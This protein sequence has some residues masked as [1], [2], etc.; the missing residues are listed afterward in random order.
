[1]INQKPCIKFKLLN[2]QPEIFDSKVGGFGY[3]PHDR[4]FPMAKEGNQL[5][6]LAQIDCSQVDFEPFPKS[7]LLQFWIL[8][9][10][11]YG[12]FD[13][14]EQD[15]FRVIYYPEIDR[16]VTKE[17]IQKKIIKSEYDED[18]YNMP[19]FGEFGM[20]FSEGK[21][22][23][24]D[25]F[26]EFVE[27]DEEREYAMATGTYAEKYSGEEETQYVTD[28]VH[29]QIGGYPYFTQDDPRYSQEKLDNYNF[30]LFQLDSD[31]TGADDRVLWG[32]TGIGN[33]FI[34]SEKLKNLDFTDVLYNWD[35]C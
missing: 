26:N 13:I 3:I 27:A 2:N 22:I 14:T 9:D 31:G 25:E 1:M 5:R 17:E 8:N 4:D 6:L 10:E 23:D 35:C 19:V 21:S 32:D 30:L 24:W 29:H 7:G 18:E 11:E 28:D 20:E 33:F 34:N 15:T 16:T 12:G